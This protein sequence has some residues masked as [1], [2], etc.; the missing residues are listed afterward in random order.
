MRINNELYTPDAGF[1]HN[2]G[3]GNLAA[4]GQRLMDKSRHCRTPVSSNGSQ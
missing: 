4:L 2:P 1:G 3:Q